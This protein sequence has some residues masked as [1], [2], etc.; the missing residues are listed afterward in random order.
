MSRYLIAVT[1]PNY[2]GRT[3]QFFA[4]LPLIRSMQVKVVL[5]DFTDATD[6]EQRIEKALKA[7]MPYID[8][9]HMPL[10]PTHSNYMVQD[11]FLS[12]FPEI[13]DIDLVCLVDADIKIQ[14]DFAQA[15]LE[16][17]YNYAYHM[18]IYAYYN[19]GE[20]D[21]LAQEA[22]RI[23]LSNEWKEK[24]GTIGDR[25]L[26]DLSCYNCGVMIAEAGVFRKVQKVY[27]EH[28]EEF[29]R[30]SAHRSRC[31]F[32]INWC[33]YKLG[34][35]ICLLPH[36][37]HQHGHFRSPDGSICLPASAQPEHRGSVLYA[38]GEP[39]IFVHNF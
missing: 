7:S 38:G 17:I 20:D 6:P 13:K 33:W 29:F 27:A 37:I 24:Y 25:T 1:T 32:L 18:N 22:E 16:R 2:V 19:G 23:D 31:Q 10:P 4:T 36:Q 30:A 28:C 8:F 35:D 15:E 12:A 9:V 14:R 26:Y 5:L 21:T 34:L 39:V 11:C 3:Q